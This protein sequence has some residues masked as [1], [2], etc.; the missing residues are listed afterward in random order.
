MSDEPHES[1]SHGR[2]T[3]PLDG[4]RRA[5]ETDSKNPSQGNSP[6]SPRPAE[7]QT[8]EAGDSKLR[9][10]LSGGYLAELHFPLVV[11]L[12]V[13]C[14]ALGAIG[15]DLRPGTDRPPPVSPYQ[16]QFT[17]FQ[18]I[19]CA[20]RVSPATCLLQLEEARHAAIMNFINQIPGGKK[21]TVPPLRFT[22][23]PTK[24]AVDETLF[25]KNSSTVQLQLDLFGIFPSAETAYWSL[26]ANIFK[27]QPYP[28]PDV[29]NYVGTTYQNPLAGTDHLTIA[30]H[31]V[32]PVLIANFE[33]QRARGAPGK[34]T[35]NGK[36]PAQVPAN[37]LAPLGE[38]NLCWHRDAPLGFD[39][40]YTAAALPAIS[41]NNS[42]IRALIPNYSGHKS[43]LEVTQSLYFE[44]PLQSTQPITSEYSLQAGSLPTR[45]DPFG[46]HWSGNSGALIQLTAL[47]ILDSQHA[48]YLG[49]IS[50]V[51]FGIAGGAFIALLQET[52]EPVRRRRTIHNIGGSPKGSR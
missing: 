10:R 12:F 41:E 3:E 22:A 38:V 37:T 51:M 11:I 42:R 1:R 30:G 2:G 6:G 4:S 31:H 40:E 44:N 14:V 35:L 46:W 48:A 16:I 19:P 28:C 8:T 24:L 23:V 47:N 26:R 52:L 33:G 9:K 21:V 29:H 15:F 43:T 34:L 5:P 45:T 20:G 13:L 18:A 49:F 36:S 39:G 25:Q 7:V 50:G 27:S 32:S 17:V